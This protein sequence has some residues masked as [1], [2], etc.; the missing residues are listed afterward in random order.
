MTLQTAGKLFAS[1]MLARE[2]MFRLTVPPSIWFGFQ[3]IAKHPRLV[4]NIA[5]MKHDVN[6]VIRKEIAA[7]SHKW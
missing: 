3:G 4:T 7:F 2:I 1:R 5:D 6:E